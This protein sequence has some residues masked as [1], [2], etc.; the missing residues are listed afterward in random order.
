MGL[1]VKKTTARKLKALLNRGLTGTPSIRGGDSARYDCFVIVTGEAEDLDSDSDSGGSDFYPC[2]VTEYDTEEGAWIELEQTCYCF[3]S[4]DEQLTVDTRYRAQCYGIL[5]DT[6]LFVVIA[7]SQGPTPRICGWLSGL[8]PENCLPLRVVSATGKCSCINTAQTLTLVWDEMQEYWASA[9]D[10]V[11]CVDE[12]QAVF[13][14]EAPDDPTLTIDGEPGYYLGCSDGELL[15]SFGG[16]DLC[17]DEDAKVCCENFFIVG[18]SCSCCTCCEWDE[19]SMAEFTVAGVNCSGCGAGGSSC[20]NAFNRSYTLTYDE[21][22]G[23]DLTATYP[24]GAFCYS[25]GIEVNAFLTC[26]DEQDVMLLSLNIGPDTYAHYQTPIT[27]WVCDGDNIMTYQPEVNCC[28]SWPATI[29]VTI[30]P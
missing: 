6:L 24:I 1:E 2:V 18:V 23:P 4:N 17:D 29:T 8:E 22:I 28:A 16:P 20:I 25:S 11:H 10:F 5:N 30:T 9:E 15:F 21:M 13:D 27:S 26:F 14:F 3:G 19:T 12:G 7:I